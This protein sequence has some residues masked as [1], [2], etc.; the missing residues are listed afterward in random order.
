MMTTLAAAVGAEPRVLAAAEWQPVRVRN[1][2]ELL[3]A[4]RARQRHLGRTD[5]QIEHDACMVAGHLNKVLGPSREKGLGALTLD[6]LMN[7]GLAFDLMVVGNADK[8]ARLVSVTPARESWDNHRVSKKAMERVR[9]AV[10][11]QNALLGV[12]ARASM[13]TSEHRT[14]IAR[15]AAKQRWKAE[16]ARRRARAKDASLNVGSPQ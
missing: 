12:E 14:R 2:N 10:L 6:K 7:E 4:L 1:L 5:A 13:L 11:R 8:E 3:D 15:F 16:R 9:P